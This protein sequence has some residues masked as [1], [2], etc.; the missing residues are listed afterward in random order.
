[1][2]RIIAISKKIPTPKETVRIKT[3]LG[4]P[5]TCSAKICR[6]GSEMVTKIPMIKLTNA[7]S[8]NFLD[9][10]RDEPILLPNGCMDI[11]APIV[12]IANPTIKQRTP[13]RNSKNVLVLSGAI[14]MP[15]INTIAAM[16]RID[17][18]DS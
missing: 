14:V 18:R 1:M 13:S 4:T 16:G 2:I 3:R 7:I 11:S 10:A 9:F 17:V 6:S 8:H 12:K 5:A 15:S